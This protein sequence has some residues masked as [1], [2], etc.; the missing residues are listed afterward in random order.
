MR[1]VGNWLLA[2]TLPLWGLLF[3]MAGL[4]WL[5]VEDLRG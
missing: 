4:T 2:L 5:A 3:V 1:L